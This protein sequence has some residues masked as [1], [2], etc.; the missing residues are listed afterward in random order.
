MKLK[1]ALS[2]CLALALALMCCACS[3]EA[4]T[5]AQVVEKMQTALT[6]SPCGKAQTTMN[7]A[8]KMEAGE[9]GTLEMSTKTTNEITIS[10]EPVTG[11]TVATVDIDYGGEKSQTIAENYTIEENGEMVSYINSSGIWMKAPTGQTPGDFVKVNSSVGFDGSNLAIDETVT[12][13]GGK[14]AICLT[15]QLSGENLKGMLDGVLN[16]LGQQGGAFSQAAETAGAIDYS[17]LT[18]DSRIYLDK[19]TYLPMGEE[20][21]F[22]GMDDLMNPM[23]AGT[24]VT[25]EVTEC[26]ATAA[27]LSFESQPA[28]TLPEGAAENAEAWTRLLAGEPDNGDGTFT[29]RE[30][31]VL[32]DIVP[33]EGFELTDKGYDHV[34]FERDDHRKVH[35]TMVYGSADHFTATIDQ[36][37]SRYGDMPNQVNREAMSLPGETLTFDC[38]IIGVE[39][40]SYE[41]G[42]IYAWAELGNDG[43][44][45]YYIF[46]EI[47]DGYNDG[48]GGVKSADITPDEFMGYLGLA[49]LSELS[50]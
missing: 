5:P 43:V 44:G 9:A 25:A 12:E 35:Y 2:V 50:Q 24:G 41:E 3:Q 47:S 15:T 14:P 30:G 8:L 28:V 36:Q 33:P 7:M 22:H 42:L 20:M 21:T 13:W 4:E 48:L 34:Y 10:H 18:C 39:W 27:F 46:V 37:L 23:L 26:T 6:E 17:A 11:Y 40:S 31:A 45:S 19:E 29:I 49:T 16:S 1:H 32:V 38:E